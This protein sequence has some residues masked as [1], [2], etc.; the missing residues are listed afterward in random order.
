MYTLKPVAIEFLSWQIITARGFPFL[1]RS[2]SINLSASQS[3]FAS[4]IIRNSILARP[5]DSFALDDH[6]PTHSIIH[7]ALPPI[8]GIWTKIGC[9]APSHLEAAS[10]CGDTPDDSF[11]LIKVL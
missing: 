7:A 11:S 10:R 5:L 9:S 6:R 8:L 4:F 2:V 1:G 3:L